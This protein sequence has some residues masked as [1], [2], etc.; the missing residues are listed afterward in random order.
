MPSEVASEVI[1]H[2]HF[3]ISHQQWCR[4]NRLLVNCSATV[5][6]SHSIRNVCNQIVS[7]NR[8]TAHRL[9]TWGAKDTQD[10]QNKQRCTSIAGLAPLQCYS[11][12]RLCV[13]VIS[14]FGLGQGILLVFSFCCTQGVYFNCNNNIAICLFFGE[15]NS[16]KC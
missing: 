7:G 6:S 4:L 14:P 11:F 3:S 10:P 9:G 16:L 8:W 5:V 15:C 12:T 13:C 2:W 1:L